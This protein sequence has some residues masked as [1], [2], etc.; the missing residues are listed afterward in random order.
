MGRVADD[1]FRIFAHNTDRK[2][3]MCFFS[4][5]DKEAKALHSTWSM[6]G[7]ILATLEGAMAACGDG[8][9]VVG[10]NMSKASGHEALVWFA[11]G[12]T[13]RIARLN[14]SSVCDRPSVSGA[15]P[16]RLVVGRGII[17][18]IVII[19]IIITTKEGQCRGGGGLEVVGR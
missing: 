18:V 14:A 4:Q 7:L 12:A 8:M 9:A 16:A 1:L 13:T 19:I 17:I 5:G 2:K 11:R 10:H 15:R 3:T 6:N